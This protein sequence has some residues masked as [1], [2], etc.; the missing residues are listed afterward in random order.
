MNRKKRVLIEMVEIKILRC[1]VDYMRN[2]TIRD[3][4]GVFNFNKTINNN[5]QTCKGCPLKV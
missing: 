4:L 2:N 3:Q 1:I 5:E